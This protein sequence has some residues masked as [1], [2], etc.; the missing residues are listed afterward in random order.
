M[1]LVYA[2]QHQP[3]IPTRNGA[4][5]VTKYQDVPKSL[6]L[7]DLAYVSRSDRAVRDSL[8]LL[9]QSGQVEEI[10]N[11]NEKNHHLEAKTQG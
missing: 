4:N 11:L 3:E 9:K 8:L 7:L 2:A 5:N 1:S 6:V 10:K